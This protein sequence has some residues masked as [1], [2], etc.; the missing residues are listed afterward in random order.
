MYEKQISVKCK[1]GLHARPASLLVKISDQYK[2][3]IEISDGIKYVNINSIIAILSLA[4]KVGN[5]IIIRA[6]GEDEIVAVDAVIKLLENEE[7]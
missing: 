5:N 4:V 6:D 1:S 3:K 7:I 2:S